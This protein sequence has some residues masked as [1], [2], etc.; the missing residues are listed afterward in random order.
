MLSAAFLSEQILHDYLS[1]SIVWLSR[2]SASSARRLALADYKEYV[3]FWIRK[4]VFEL[5]NGCDSF[6]A[7]PSGF[8]H[9]VYQRIQPSKK[10]HF[11]NQSTIPII[12]FAVLHKFSSVVRLLVQHWCKWTTTCMW[13]YCLAHR[14]CY[15][16]YKTFDRKW[17]QP[18]CSQWRCSK[19]CI[20]RWRKYIY[21]S[22]II[23]IFCDM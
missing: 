18:G 23:E 19:L 22:L 2:R 17:S 15:R 13:G 21:L 1:M 7:C 3:I 16:C 6:D 14:I 4:V 9:W 20:V 8:D 5:F 10:Y 11:S 12:H